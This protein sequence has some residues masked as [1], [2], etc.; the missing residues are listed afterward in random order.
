MA[1]TVS[2][3][4]AEVRVPRDELG[5]VLAVDVKERVVPCIDEQQ[6]PTNCT[7]P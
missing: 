4:E 2:E 1:A 6:R 5:A 7:V 3:E